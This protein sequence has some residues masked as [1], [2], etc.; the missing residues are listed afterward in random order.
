MNLILLLLHLKLHFLI[1][2]RQI[3]Q[4]ELDAVVFRLDLTILVFEVLEFSLILEKLVV[5][6]QFKG[7][8]VPSYVIS[9]LNIILSSPLGFIKFPSELL[10]EISVPT[11]V[12]LLL[13][14]LILQHKLLIFSLKPVFEILDFFFILILLGLK[15]S[16]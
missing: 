12:S 2:I 6:L 3:L 15:L 16:P 10:D 14:S 4:L 11:V 9:I 5:F 1:L 13:K 7:V 8:T